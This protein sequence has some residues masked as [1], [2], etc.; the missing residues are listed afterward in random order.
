MPPF[1]ILAFLFFIGSMVGWGLEVVFRRFFS[2]ANPS[3]RWINPG[4]LIGPYLPLYGL[5]LCIL[6]MLAG[7]E[8]SITILDPVLEKVV[9]FVFMAICVTALEYVTGVLSE[10]VFNVKLWD[11]SKQWG[12]INGIICPKFTLFW[13]ILSAIYYFLVHP[14]ILEALEWLS[15]NLAF[16]FFIG[17]FF[18]VFTLDVIYSAKL[19]PAIRRFASESGLVVRFEELKE[20]IRV[21]KEEAREKNRFIFSM[22]SS[23]P[24]SEH[25][26]RYADRFHNMHDKT[27]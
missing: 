24:L 5:S 19:L 23:R 9:L 10:S 22:R 25:L 15:E 8:G 18:G 16:S 7:F 27:A 14:R 3:R 13:M 4:F 12:N 11:Y 1:L 20:Q 17:F 2:S 26:A 21:Y 6:Y